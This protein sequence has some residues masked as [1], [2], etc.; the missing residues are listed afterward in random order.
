MNL[1]DILQRLGWQRKRPGFYAEHNTDKIIRE[2]LFPDLSFKGVMVE[3][4]G[5]TPEFLSMSKHFKESGW[6]TIIIEPNPDFV[7]QHRR[8]GNEV[9]QFACSSEDCS[10]VPFT[11]VSQETK[12]YGGIVTDHSFSSINIKPEYAALMPAS[13]KAKKILVEVRRL[14]G[15]LIKLGLA[16][17]DLLSIDVEGW[18]I[19]VL[20]GLDMKKIDCPTIVIENFNH[21]P[22]YT[23]YMLRLGYRLIRQIEYNYIFQKG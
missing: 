11:V 1:D 12:A 20:Q 23:K 6:R 13:A 5:G 19:E 2:E 3:V 22:S 21:D 16:K 9:Y 4:G 10:D 18:E 14:D 17:I 8:I 15:L 7:E